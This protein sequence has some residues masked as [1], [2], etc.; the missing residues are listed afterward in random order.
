MAII[1]PMAVSKGPDARIDHYKDVDSL[2]IDVSNFLGVGGR[3]AL[4]R[5]DWR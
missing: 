2:T 5:G 1:S 3:V 4:A